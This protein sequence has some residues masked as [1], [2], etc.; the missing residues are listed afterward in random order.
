MGTPAAEFAGQS[1]PLEVRVGLPQPLLCVS[2]EGRGA[3]YMPPPFSLP[4][5]GD[6]L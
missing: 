2:Q 5:N 1:Y 4:A 3:M 6:A